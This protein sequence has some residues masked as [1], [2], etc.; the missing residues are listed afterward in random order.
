MIEIARIVAP[1]GIRGDVKVRLY[2][3]GFDEFCR[4]GFAYLK[5]AEGRQRCGFAALRI[6]PPFVYVHLDGVDTRNDAEPLRNTP[7][8]VLS[9][10]MAP[11]GEGE[12]F[13]K[14]II[15]LSVTAGGKKLGVLK[16]VLQHGAADVYV[17]KGERNFMFPALK[18]VILRIDLGAGVIALNEAALGE[19]AVYDDL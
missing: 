13:I 11:P 10:E 6:D 3:D 1:H 9:S 5:N 18:R 17:V 7:L 2:S 8:F 19:V 12:Y 4:R 15:G 14:D 16:D